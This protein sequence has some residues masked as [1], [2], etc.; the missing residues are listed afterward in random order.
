M[1]QSH[2]NTDENAQRDVEEENDCQEEEEEMNDVDSD[3]CASSYNF[4]DDSEEESIEKRETN[5]C[6]VTVCGEPPRV[7]CENDVQ[8]NYAGS[9]ELSSYSSIDE[10]ELVPN[11]PKYS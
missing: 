1:V 8:L 3:L 6:V 10:D 2:D 9:K 11:R 7:A 4:S 5:R